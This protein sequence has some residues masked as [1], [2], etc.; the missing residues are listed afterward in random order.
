MAKIEEIQEAE[1]RLFNPCT[2]CRVTESRFFFLSAST[3][4]VVCLCE[5]CH[6]KMEDSGMD[7]DEWLHHEIASQN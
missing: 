7:R 1:A 2:I 3:G 5:Q 4:A 6:A